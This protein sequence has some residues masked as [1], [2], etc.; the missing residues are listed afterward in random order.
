M[1][2]SRDDAFSVF[3]K[4]KEEGSL[5]R[6][7]GRI[8]A[9]TFGIDG[10]IVSASDE[11]LHV[12][13]RGCTGF[14]DLSGTDAEFEYAESHELPEGFRDEAISTFWQITLS[15][16]FIVLAEFRRR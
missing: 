7:T 14:L 2:S 12:R 6:L 1:R 4:L 9:I 10:R 13:G 16:G 5:V 3:R 8:D 11:Q 15:T